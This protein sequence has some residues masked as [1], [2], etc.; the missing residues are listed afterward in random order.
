MKKQIVKIEKK[1]GTEIDGNMISRK[2]AIKKTGYFAVSAATMMILLSSPA[3]ADGP[4][5]SKP[6]A[7]PSTQ[8]PNNGGGIWKKKN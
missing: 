3:L 4:H 1:Q 8:K 7:C 5:A 2:E 6:E